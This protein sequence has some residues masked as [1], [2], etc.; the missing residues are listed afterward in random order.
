MNKK[1]KEDV[2]ER[3]FSQFGEI[4]DILINRSISDNSSK[5]CAF[6][7]FKN[8]EVAQKLILSKQVHLI[9]GNYV[10]VKKCYEK[11]RSKALKEE[12]KNMKKIMNGGNNSNFNDLP[13]TGMMDNNLMG[14]FMNNF[15]S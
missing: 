9:E 6:L 14:L 3:Y 11:S 10:E 15:V 7:L 8:F 13:F 1:S 4:E 12:K 2:I 5:G